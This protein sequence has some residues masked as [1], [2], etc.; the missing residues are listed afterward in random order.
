MDNSPLLS[1]PLR[2]STRGNIQNE[3]E[4]NGLVQKSGEKD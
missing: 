1:A 3:Y 4:E 2:K